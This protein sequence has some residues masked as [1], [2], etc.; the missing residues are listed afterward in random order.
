VP[1]QT[2]TRKLLHPVYLD[3]PMMV[4]FLAALTEGVS[5]ESETT[6]QTGTSGD[7]TKGGGVGIRV[8]AIS[9]LLGF[10]ASGRISRSEHDEE[11]QQIRAVRQH[12]AASLFNAL[13]AVLSTSDSVA[14]VNDRSD[15]DGLAPGDMAVVNGDFAGNPLLDLLSFF[16]RAM[17]YFA[18]TEQSEEV[19][20]ASQYDFEA[21]TQEVA[22]LQGETH[23]LRNE[24][25]KAARS[26]NPSRSA[27]ADQ[28]EQQAAALEG[29]FQD[30]L[31]VATKHLEVLQQ[32]QVN[33]RGLLMVNQMREDLA[34]TPVHD[35]VLKTSTF[36]AVLTL[37]A[38]FFT[39][40]TS[41]FLLA[42]VFT[43]IGKV[44]KVLGNGEQ[45]NLMRRTVLGPAGADF[46]RNMIANAS[47]DEDFGSTL[48]TPSSSRPLSRSSR[49]RCLSRARPPTTP[50]E[51]PSG[52]HRSGFKSPLRSRGNPADP[53]L[54]A[55][56]RTTKDSRDT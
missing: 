36:Q 56:S 25:Q 11:N 43:V 10:D 47:A 33:N 20:A 5:F 53:V 14:F 41:A 9:S 50:A 35:C 12:T 30:M 18:L 6:L 13:Y 38:E 31:G 42:G 24:A 46:A 23:R 19:R 8:P 44:T 22:T 4:S 37:S 32:W 39:D 28:L 34:Q 29:Q 1:D 48:S 54:W 15:L 17:P 27:E 7:R 55:S 52:G 3:V 40:T 51:G 45:I 26:G 16:A 49:S 2:D 21:A